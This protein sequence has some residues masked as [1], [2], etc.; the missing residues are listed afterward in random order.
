MFTFYYYYSNIFIIFIIISIKWIFTAGWGTMGK[1]K[2]MSTILQQV[3]VPVNS[4]ERCKGR[5]FNDGEEEFKFDDRVLCA[6]FK[7]GG[8]NRMKAF[9]SKTLKFTQLYS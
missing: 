8:K 6:G 9:H 7:K 4:N 5:Y 2:R 1:T 3:Q